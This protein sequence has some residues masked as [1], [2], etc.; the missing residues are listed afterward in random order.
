MSLLSGAIKFGDELSLE[1]CQ[2]LLNDLKKCNAPFQCAHGRPSIA[3]IVELDKLQMCMR[4]I[5]KQPK[6]NL[7]RLKDSKGL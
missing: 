1:K 3:P 2:S 5:K 6:L 7:K 4:E